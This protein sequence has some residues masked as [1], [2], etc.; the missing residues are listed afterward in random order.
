MWEIRVSLSTRVVEAVE[1]NVK[2]RIEVE[3]RPV[4]AVGALKGQAQVR[5]EDLAVVLK[6]VRWFLGSERIVEAQEE[7]LNARWAYVREP[8]GSPV[9]WVMV[10]GGF[11]SRRVRRRGD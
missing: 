1:G 5:A 10:G 9:R 11:A 3:S 7:M 4:E 8:C 6:D 2:E